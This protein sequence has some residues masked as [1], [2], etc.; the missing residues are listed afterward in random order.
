MPRL[1]R[2]GM[3]SVDPRAD[4]EPIWKGLEALQ[5]LQ[6]ELWLCQCPPL[7]KDDFG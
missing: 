7:A 5:S 3:M 1:K 4:G 2:V 6:K